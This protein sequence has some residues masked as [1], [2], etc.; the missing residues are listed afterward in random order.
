MG[1]QIG[2][3]VG[4]VSLVSTV[5]A[6][7]ICLQWV[8]GSLGLLNA[9]ISSGRSLEDVGVLNHLTLWGWKIHVQLPVALAKTAAEQDGTQ[10][11]LKT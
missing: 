2:S 1:A 6:P 3:S 9:L 5:V 10:I 8:F 4:I 11:R 7:M